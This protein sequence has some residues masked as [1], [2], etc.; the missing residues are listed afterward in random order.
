MNLA[1]HATKCFVSLD[2]I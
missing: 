2:N 1:M